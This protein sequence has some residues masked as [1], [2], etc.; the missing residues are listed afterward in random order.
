MPFAGVEDFDRSFNYFASDK[1]EGDDV[2][3]V[4]SFLEEFA[5]GGEQDLLNTTF[6][7]EVF[8]FPVTDSSLLPSNDPSTVSQSLQFAVFPEGND[9]PQN[10][11]PIVHVNV[12]EQLSA[13]YDDLSQEGTVLVTG[14]ICVQ[15]TEKGKR[16]KLILEDDALNVQRIES[17]H[18]AKSDSRSTRTSREILVDLQ[19][20]KSSDEVLIAKYFCSHK[21]RPVPLVRVYSSKAT[22]P[23]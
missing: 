8:Q 22:Q 20:A 21:L 3:P 18:A 1:G 14:S 10:S 19:N 16:F 7:S 2:R 9:Q 12:C 15:S 5:G 11:T 23:C 4:D 13:M 6:E 17:T